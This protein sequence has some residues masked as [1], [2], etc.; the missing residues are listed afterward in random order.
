MQGRALQRAADAIGGKEELRARLRVPA[1]L[2]ELWMAGRR[3]PPVEIFLKAVDLAS[4]QPAI[5][6]AIA[7]ARRLRLQARDVLEAALD[8][9]LRTARTR[10]GNVQ[11]ACDDGLRIAAQRGFERPFLDFFACVRDQASS[12]GVAA[13]RGRRVIVADIAREPPFAGTLAGEVMRE[14]GALAVQSTP[15]L[16]ASG[17]LIGVLSTHYDE[18]L[19]PSARALEAL[20]RLARRTASWLEGGPPP[21]RG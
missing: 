2:L 9:A 17:E 8:E 18:P 10:M 14:A 1:P 19:V 20:D 7:S 13:A 6:E 3:R 4:G 11:L 12:C 16:A 5:Q 15:L 21:P